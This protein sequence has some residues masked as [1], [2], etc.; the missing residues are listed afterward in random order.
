[1][2][3]AEFTK[4]CREYNFFDAEHPSSERII[5]IMNRLKKA[6]DIIDSLKK[7]GKDNG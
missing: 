7:G 5:G 3:E 1:M 2:D 6:C 4:E